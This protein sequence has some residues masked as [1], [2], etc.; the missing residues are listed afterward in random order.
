MESE[1]AKQ[2]TSAAASTLGMAS[3]LSVMSSVFN[4]NQVASVVTVKSEL[5][6]DCFRDENKKLETIAQAT[7]LS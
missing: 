4:N 5:K 2:S 7:I 1:K 3:M 6:E